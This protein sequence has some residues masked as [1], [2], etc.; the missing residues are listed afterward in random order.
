MDIFPDTLELASWTI[1][2]DVDLTNATADVQLGGTWHA[3]TWEGAAVF[4]ADTW[5]RVA[6]ILVAG[7]NPVTGVHLTEADAKPLVRVLVGG[8]VIVHRS[9]QRFQVI[10]A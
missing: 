7:A 4:A 5:T 6:Q 2:A 9:T 8:E 10:E 3:L 1:K